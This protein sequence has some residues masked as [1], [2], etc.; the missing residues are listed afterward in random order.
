MRM[1]KAERKTRI[2]KTAVCGI[3]TVFI[4]GFAALNLLAGKKDF[5]ENENRMLEP[6]PQATAQNIF[7][8]SFDTQFENWFSDHFVFRDMWIEIKAA[9]RKGSGAIEN[10]DVYF[11]KD[12]RLIS[13]FAGYDE[14]TAG[15]NI[16]Y[17]QEFSEDN[18][19]T[20]N[21]MLVP[22]AVY[23]EREYLPWG[24]A[25][26]DEKKLIED[27]GTKLEGQNYIDLTDS[28]DG[29]SNDFFKTDHHWNENGAYKGYEAI[30]KEVL[31]K[32]PM[33][34][35]L[36]KV[37]AGFK[38]SMYSRSGAF[39]MDGEA[40]HRITPKTE[41]NVKVT[42]EDGNTEDSFYNEDNLAIKD[43]YTYYLDG[44]HAHVH[45]ETDADTNRKA[46]VI[47]DSFSHI[48]IPY[49]ACEYKETEVFDLR[50]WHEQ[51]STYI[52]DPENTDV[53]IIYG[54]ET[55]CTDNNL[56]VLW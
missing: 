55:F 49:L 36:E 39:W 19:I 27:I 33:D 11:A 30:C 50:Y 32:E 7:F 3:F 44:N 51:V 26:V 29:S 16:S 41:M 20:V 5:S 48:L 43:K 17:I 10:N 14:K 42:Y 47:R 52:T 35:E 18:G 12:R 2:I 8:G 21:V 23:G 53:Y 46:V 9:L 25:D 40:I 31:H 38:G 13:R 6:A 4:F 54:I 22:S 45:I 24:S 15:D 37:Q 28:F 56:A 1:N 34:F